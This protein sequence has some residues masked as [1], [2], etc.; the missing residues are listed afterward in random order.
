MRGFDFAGTADKATVSVYPDRTRL[1]MGA[2]DR[3]PRWT[4]IFSVLIIG[5]PC[6]HKK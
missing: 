5:A 1:T 6:H 2:R 3:G 4:A